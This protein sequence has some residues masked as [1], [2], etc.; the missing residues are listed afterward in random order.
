[1]AEKLART[2][3]KLSKEA[4]YLLEDKPINKQR[5]DFTA[6]SLK[7][8]VKIGQNVRRENYGELCCGRNRSKNTGIG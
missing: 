1:M 2:R 8:E 4:N 5:L 7:R 3:A 6:S